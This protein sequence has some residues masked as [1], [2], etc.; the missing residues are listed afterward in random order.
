MPHSQTI[1]N[2]VS[3]NLAIGSR[4]RKRRE[5]LGFSREELSKL[6]GI[7]IKF[8]YEVETGKKGLSSRSII[9]M[10]QY[11]MISCDYILL[12]TPCPG[13]QNETLYAL[14]ASI[15]DEKR[16]QITDLLETIIHMVNISC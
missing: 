6:T 14:I 7:S 15:T 12:G 11:L 9:L 1:T 3:D 2:E 4:I 10:S 16:K 5:E 8:L 13:Y